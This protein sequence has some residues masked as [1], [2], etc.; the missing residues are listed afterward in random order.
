MGLVVE[1]TDTAEEAYDALAE[2]YDASYVEPKDLAE[3]NWIASR[4][5]QGGWS[6]GDLLDVGCG[7]GLLL[8]M[9]P[10]DPSRYL[11][12]DVSEKML[13][14][15]RDKHLGY[16]FQRG[17]MG[18]LLD[19]AGAGQWDRLIYLFGTFSYALDLVAIRQEI[20]GLLRPGGRFFIMALSRRYPERDSYSVA[21]AGYSVPIRTYTATDLVGDLLLSGGNLQI[22][23]VY[24]LSVLV[25]NLQW[26]PPRL[27]D[28]YYR[29]EARTLGRWQP[30]R[31]AY[32]IVEGTRP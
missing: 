9:L 6:D 7:T 20:E 3:N 15:A 23:D 2:Y 29:I 10:I 19:V 30:D 22:D 1:G 16:R 8:D 12:V 26:L 18:R 25:D 17:A 28:A 5:T 21:N 32:I 27:L 4:L 13:G 11:G 31:A 24:G 14:V